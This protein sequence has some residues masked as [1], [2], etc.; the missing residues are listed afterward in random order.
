[1][2]FAKYPPRT[3]CELERLTRNPE[4]LANASGRCWKDSLKQNK[5]F[6][7]HQPPYPTRRR[8]VTTW[9]EA[10]KLVQEEI[11]MDNVRKNLKEKTIENYQDL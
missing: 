10:K 2:P 5:S 6:R 7:T 3:L 9:Q 1:M 8:L 11:W 4:K